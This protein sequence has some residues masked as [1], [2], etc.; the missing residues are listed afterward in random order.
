M[1]GSNAINTELIA[2]ADPVVIRYEKSE[3]IDTSIAISK[4]V[5]EFIK[6]TGLTIARVSQLIVK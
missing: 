5:L 6:I 4:G 2:I 1:P 3:S